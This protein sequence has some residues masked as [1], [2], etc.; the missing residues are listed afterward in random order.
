MS[1]TSTKL[2]QT[3]NIQNSLYDYNF[4][5]SLNK[6][7]YPKYLKEFFKI[8]T[9]EELNLDN[10][11]TFNEK[12]QWLKLYD[13][14]P[15]KSLLSDKVKVRYWIKDKI[16]EKYL[17]PLVWVGKHF[18]DIPFK[19]L[20]E[21]FVIKANHGCKWQYMIKSKNKFLR[22][23]NLFKYI[24]MRF[25]GWMQQTFFPFAGFEMQYKN[26]EPQILIEP[27]LLHSPSD[28]PTEYEIYCFNSVPKIY[29][30]IKYTS[31]PV[32]TVYNDD[33]SISIHISDKIII[34][35]IFNIF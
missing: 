31:P 15:L 21:A 8:E 6:K 32:V 34:I 3:K 27:L 23:E 7:E 11:K 1:L 29:Q 14:T 20:P 28:S 18:D 22:E 26:I 24:K 33:F 13:C 12:I 35:S 17:K 2:N 25:D 16:G 10:P 9:G 19:E 30:K 4:L 5:I